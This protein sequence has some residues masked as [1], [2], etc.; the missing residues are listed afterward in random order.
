MTAVTVLTAALPATA[1]PPIDTA[2]SCSLTL[3]SEYAGAPLYGMSF[4]LYRAATVS[5]SGRYTLCADY[6]GS[7]AEVNGITDASGWRA[8][9]ESLAAWTAQAGLTPLSRATTDADGK[10]S[11]AALTPGLYLV[12]ATRMIR[13][14]QQYICGAFLTA[15]PGI[16]DAGDWYTDVTVFCK[17]ES[18]PYTPPDITGTTSPVS[19]TE[20]GETT[21]TAET[22]SPA[23]TTTPAET[24]TSAAESTASEPTGTTEPGGDLPQTGQLKWPV[25]VMFTLGVLLSIIGI[26]LRRRDDDA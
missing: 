2:A 13:G 22:T 1:A 8:A 25:P 5:E 19:T 15:L 4:A 7:G 6:A 14:R 12:G 21:S 18:Q 11:F 17:V 26:L 9:A 16:T 23:E 24:G 3:Q 10:A 20:P